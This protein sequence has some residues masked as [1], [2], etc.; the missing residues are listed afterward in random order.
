MAAIGK[1]RCPRCAAKGNDTSGDNLIVYDDEGKYCFACDY[2]VLS[3]E[4]LIKRGGYE[5][6]GKTFDKSVEDTI[7]NYSLDPNGFRGLTKKTCSKYR[8]RHKYDDEG[9]MIEQYYPA[10]KEYELSGYKVRLNPKDFDAYG[11]TGKACEMFG[12]FVFRNTNSKSVIVTGGELDALSAYQIM[13]DYQASKGNDEYE[14]IPVVSCTVGEQSTAKQM[15]MQY[16]WFNKF[17][18]IILCLDND[19]A[20]HD[21][22]MECLN[23]LPKGKVYR[24]EMTMKDPNEYLTAGRNREFVSAFYSAK[25]IVPTGVIGSG[26]LY[27]HMLDSAAVPKIPLPPFMRRLSDML[28]GGIALGHI[29]NLASSSGTGKTSVVNEMLYYWMYNSPHKLGVVSMELNAG[30]YGISMLSRHMGVKIS[31]MSSEDQVRFLD[32]ES[33]KLAVE[34]L[35]KDENGNDRWVLV[36]D[37]DGTVS[38]MQKVVESLIVGCGCK[39]IVLDPMSDII[40]G[41]SNEEQAL[42]I[43]W[44]KGMIKSHNVTFINICH[45]RKTSSGEKS[46]SEGAN[47]TEE[48]I[49]G[50]SSIFKSSSANILFSRN[51]YAE[52]DIERNTLTVR[53]SKNRVCGD[54]GEAGKWFYDYKSSTLHDLDDWKV[55]IEKA[56][57]NE[58]YL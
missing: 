43:K 53:L 29:V 24:L 18:K 4:E 48:S 33:T 42:F 39:V 13:T 21:A 44:Q 47:L 19:D 46:A 54:T 52:D 35:L 17:D 3:K 57:F 1:E 20:G 14:P 15:Q 50:S 26:S 5:L 7:R 38:D 11:T 41:L 58:G 27:P 12:Q 9:T 10:T 25:P 31:K 23:V 55:S 16:E 28:G 34:E 30:Q 40:E 22:T 36:D 37:R 45:T 8:V 56:M 32:S 49:F 6:V 51:K 2:T